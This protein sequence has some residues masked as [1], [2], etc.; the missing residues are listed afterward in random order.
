MLKQTLKRRN[1]GG[2]APPL[3]STPGEVWETTPALEGNKA[4]LAS[5]RSLS[6]ALDAHCVL[7]PASYFSRIGETKR[8]FGLEFDGQVDF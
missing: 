7:A 1:Q 2:N 3:I 6:S 4:I 8:G 5:I